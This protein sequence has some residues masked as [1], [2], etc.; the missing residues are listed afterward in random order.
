MWRLYVALTC[1]AYMRRL[2]AAP[3]RR[4][5]RGGAMWWL[6]ATVASGRL[7]REGAIVTVTNGGY[8]R[9][10][11]H[12]RL[13]RRRHSN[14]VTSYRTT[15]TSWRLR[16]R[17]DARHDDGANLPPEGFQRVALWHQIRSGGAPEVRA[18]GCDPVGISWD[19]VG[20][21]LR[22]PLCLAQPA[23]PGSDSQHS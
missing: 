8:I 1:G 23:G 13:S 15:V 10:L 11:C 3:M 2:H 21:S 14:R 6:H 5:H 18:D 17:H 4:L 16:A 9:R 20:I 19:P 12:S 7:H 22:P